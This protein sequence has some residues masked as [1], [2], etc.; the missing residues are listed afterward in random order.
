MPE[1][2]VRTV[3]GRTTLLVPP[4]SLTSK[5]PP[6]TPAFFNQAARLSRDLSIIAYRAYLPQLQEKTFADGFGG[7]GAR[8]LRVAT[9][10]PQVSRVFCNDINSIAIQAAR[11]TE[12]RERITQAVEDGTLSQAKADWLLEGLDQGF[13]FIHAVF[14]CISH[15]IIQNDLYKAGFTEAFHIP[16]NTESHFSERIL[17][18]QSVFD[19]GSDLA[20]AD[21]FFY[22]LFPL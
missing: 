12:L 9:E 17:Q 3:E 16:G 5:V 21:P 10:I 19:S 18:L 22:Y 4:E 20:E 2:F 14:P 7:I 1:E 8:A 13:L 11:E 6:K 15:E